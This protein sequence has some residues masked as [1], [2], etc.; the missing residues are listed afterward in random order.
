M[1]ETS[2]SSRMNEQVAPST[3]DRLGE[4]LVLH[5]PRIPAWKTSLAALLLTGLLGV[6]ASAVPLP[7]SRVLPAYLVRVEHGSEAEAG[8]IRVSKRES[9]SLDM[10]SGHSPQ[11]SNS[12]EPMG[13]PILLVIRADVGDAD[14]GPVALVSLELD[15]YPLNEFGVVDLVGRKIDDSFTLPLRQNQTTTHGTAVD[16]ETGMTGRVTV[17]L[18]SRSL[19]SHG[20]RKMLAVGK[21]S[22]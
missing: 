10:A 7:H 13:R 19:L 21:E 11:N 12:M 22:D 20:L 14:L 6:A 3:P 18:V 16:L 5:P 4:S 17:R 8:G 2:P 15:A 1:L 9:V